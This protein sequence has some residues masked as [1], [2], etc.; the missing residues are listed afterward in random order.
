MALGLSVILLHPILSYM[1]RNGY[2]LES[3]CQFASFDTGILHE[4]EARIQEED[5]DRLL[6]AASAFTND[7]QF[8]LHIGQSIELSSLGILG[9]VLLHCQ[10]IE[11]A[12]FAYRKYNVILCN[13]IHIEWNTDQRETVI[14]FNVYDS[15]RQVSRHAVEGMVSSV[16]QMLLKLSCRNVVLNRLQFAH[17]APDN[18][19]EYFNLFGINPR[20]E[21]EAN[22]I[23]LENEVMRYPIIFSNHE[24]LSTFETYAEEARNQLL[25][26]RTF[27]DQVYKWIAQRMP[28]TFPGVK[29]A[30]RNFNVSIRTLQAN[31]KHEKTTYNSLFNKARMEFAVQYLKN[32]QFTVAEIAYLLQFSEP[33]AFQSAFKRWTGL[34][35]GQ[36]RETRRY[37]QRGEP[38]HK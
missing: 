38:Y 35:P 26:G 2:D 16:Y 13:G 1:V 6:E 5:F 24:L 8:G 10:T 17:E 36:Y 19:E 28:S 20:F 12:L 22:L 18:R 25:H 15:T 31:L 9:Y 7:Q 23:C 3:F 14:Q 34:P 29:D 27:A 30:A 32:P 33:S 37:S 11:D 4:T 21:S